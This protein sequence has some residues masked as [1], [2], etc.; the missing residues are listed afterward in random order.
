MHGF[1]LMGRVRE[2]FLFFLHSSPFLSPQVT[3][4]LGEKVGHHNGLS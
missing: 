1:Y 4:S 3:G 2:F